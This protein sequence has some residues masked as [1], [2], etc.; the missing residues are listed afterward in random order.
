MTRTELIEKQREEIKE[1]SAR[2]IELEE[3]L[4]KITEITFNW[5]NDSARTMG[6]NCS[7]CPQRSL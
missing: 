2:I 1:L 4:M 5:R 3:A 7:R 6:D